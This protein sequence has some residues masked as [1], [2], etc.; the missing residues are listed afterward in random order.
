MCEADFCGED[1][2]AYYA[3]K[4]FFDRER[5]YRR[6]EQEEAMKNRL[7]VK[8]GMLGDLKQYLTQSGWVLEEPVGK[9][10]VLRA[11]N[12]NYQWPLLIHDRDGRGCGY[13]IDERD[14]KIYRG[15]QRSRRRRGLDPFN[16]SPEEVEN[17]LKP[18]WN[19][20]KP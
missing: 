1:A 7:T 4:D 15:W 11:R 16:P 17:E 3:N 2:G 19:G 8:H 13:S 10:E 9:Y 12:K 20:V 6:Q 18:F 5:F 14:M